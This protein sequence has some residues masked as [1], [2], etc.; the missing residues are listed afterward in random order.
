MQ[1]EPVVCHS[2]IADFINALGIKKHVII[3]S[4]LAFGKKRKLDSSSNIYYISGVG[5]DGFDPDYEKLGYK[6]LEEYNPNKKRWEHI[7]SVSEGLINDQE[8]QTLIQEHEDE[9]LTDFDYFPSL[10]FAALFYFFK[11]EGF[12]VTC[13]MSYCSEGD[14]ISDSFLLADQACKVLNLSPEKINGIFY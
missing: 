11:A 5:N 1:I 9:P 2:Y 3:L 10:P 8:T 7:I 12:R 13:L 4:S 14:N 6:K